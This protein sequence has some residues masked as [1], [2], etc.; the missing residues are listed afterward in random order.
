MARLSIERRLLISTVCLFLVIGSVLALTVRAYARRAADEAFDRVLTASALAIADTVGIEEGEVT[1]DIPYSA[2]AILGT[3]RLNRVFYKVTAPDGSLATG[4]PILG[5]DIPAVRDRAL[6]LY[7]ALYRENPVRIASVQRYRADTVTGAGGWIGVMVAET[8]EARQELA[9][10][11]TVKGMLPAVAIA[12]LSGGLILV[13]VR[14][15][16]SPLRLIESNLRARRPSDLSRI[17]KEVPV[18]VSALVSALNEFMDRLGSVLD[19]V[20]RVTADAAHQLRTPLA[21]IQAQAEVGLDEA[22]D[23]HLK[24]RLSRIYHN[25]REAGLLANML[26]SDA[27][28]MHRLETQEREIIDFRKAAEDA[29]QMLKA[30]SA[31]ANLMQLLVLNMQESP[32]PIVAE[33]VACR[34]M[35]RNIVENAFIHAP[36]PTCVHLSIWQGHAVLQVMDRGPGIPDSSKSKVFQRFAR[37]HERHPG[38]GLGLAI[39][40]DV[41][42]AFGGAISIADRA[43][44]GLIVEVALPIVADGDAS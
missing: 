6:H 44:G 5:L 17:E 16:F 37:A 43:G 29:L 31:Y 24:R 1:V 26:L 13:S 21:A 10:E 22:E 32:V 20:K 11:L 3:S 23:P 2:F 9:G 7:D 8:R 33:H 36:G 27:T 38:T 18:E 15:A 28:T 35:V 39:A 34:E 41:A 40:K 12:L 30:E 42:V 19:G 4:S 25:A 14:S